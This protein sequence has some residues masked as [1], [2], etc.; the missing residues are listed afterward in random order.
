MPKMG[1]LFSVIF[2]SSAISALTPEMQDIDA[3]SAAAIGDRT[4]VVVFDVFDATFDVDV[5]DDTFVVD[6]EPAP[7]VEG[8]R[9]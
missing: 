2:I 3:M 8:S 9:L 4:T 5:F 7:R 6:V 1:M